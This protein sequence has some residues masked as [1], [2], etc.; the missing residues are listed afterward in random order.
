MSV[1]GVS[2]SDCDCISNATCTGN[3]D[4][5]NAGT[6]VCGT[7][8]APCPGENQTCVSGVCTCNCS[9]NELCYQDNSV[10]RCCT[11][12]YSYGTFARD[13]PNVPT[14]G[15]FESI[16]PATLSFAGTWDSDGPV[17]NVDDTSGKLDGTPFD[18]VYGS[19]QGSG[20]ASVQ[21]ASANRSA[22]FTFDTPTVPGFGF[23]L[24]DVDAEN[25]FVKAF[26]N[27]GNELT[28]AEL[29]YE[30]SFNYESQSDTPVWVQAE[31]KLQGGG[32]DTGG[33]SAWFQPKKPIKTLVL[34]CQTIIGSPAYQLW[35]AAPQCT[36]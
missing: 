11:R 25:V 16:S 18:Q 15:T 33:A 17:A 10:P 35:M 2:C 8:G 21:C 31:S 9:A 34:T 5:C 27:D 1:C 3:S 30:S 23:T 13:S 29:G 12:I 7:T 26:D 28:G 14:S 20:Y 32:A 19:S 24:G 36:P 6:C 22:N 4:T